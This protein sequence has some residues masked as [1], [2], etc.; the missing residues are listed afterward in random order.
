MF[1]KPVK[2]FRVLFVDEKNELT[3]QIAEYFTRSLFDDRYEVFSA[4]PA[5]DMVDCELVSVMYR[6]G[7]DL[8]RQVSKDF[9]DVDHLPE[10]GQYDYIIFTRQSVFDEWAEKTPW[11]GKQ[12]VHEMGCT[13]DFTATDDAE[14]Y[15]CYKEM[16]NRVR[17]WV[18]KNM[19][20][21]EGLKALVS[22]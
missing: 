8:R 5:Q 18:E 16:M 4:G 19:K 10:D 2:K 17:E 15:D 6:E 14:L 1:K 7:E 22:A 3:S 9:K 20:D 11:K 21:P 12:I 13:K